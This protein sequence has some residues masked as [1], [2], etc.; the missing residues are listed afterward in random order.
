MIRQT[1]GMADIEVNPVCSG[2]RTLW[3]AEVT[4]DDGHTEMLHGDVTVVSKEK[5]FLPWIKVAFDD[6]IEY[7][8]WLKVNSWIKPLLKT[9]LVTIDFEEVLFCPKYVT[10]NE[11]DQ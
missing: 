7:G 10:K 1:F 5:K 4:Y 6:I 3:V 8:W 2:V 9:I 11:F